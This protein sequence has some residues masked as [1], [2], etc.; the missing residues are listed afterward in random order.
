MSNWM[1]PATTLPATA[2]VPGAVVATATP[3]VERTTSL[4]VLST[5]AWKPEAKPESLFNADA[6]SAT[7][8]YVP[9]AP[10]VTVAEAEPAVNAK[11]PVAR[12]GVAI[13]NDVPPEFVF[14]A[15]ATPAMF[16]VDR[17]TEIWLSLVPF[18]TGWMSENHFAALPVALYG[19]VLFMAGFAYFLLAHCL[20][21]HHGKDSTLAAALGSDVK[22][23]LSLVCYGVAIPL[24]FLVE[25]LA[26]G[27]YVLVALIW[28]VPD[29]RFEKLRSE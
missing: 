21:G 26:V 22:G 28:L 17:S 1:P 6:M 24:A 23:K 25:W 11:A 27:I 4:L 10:R 12:V 5:E 16:A 29:R 20:A 3:V 19:V 7:V 9:A 2:P 8:L 14:S 18:V 15:V 13:A